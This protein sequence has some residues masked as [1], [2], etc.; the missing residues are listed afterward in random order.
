MTRIQANL[1]LLF[2]GAIWGGG[3]IMQTFAMAS[4]KPLWYIGLRF[5]LATLVILPFALAETRRISRRLTL[6]EAIAFT[7][8]GFS[9]FAGAITQQFGLLTTT[10]TNSGF[11]TGLYVIFVPILSVI[12]LRKAPHWIIWPAALMALTGIFLLSGGSLS[13]LSQGDMLTIVC[14]FFFAIQVLLI[15]VFAAASG[16]PL[17]LSAWQFGLTS[18]A[19]LIVAAAIE[20]VSIE[21]IRSAMMPIIYSG[22]FS[23]GLAFS[24]QV[25][26]QRYTSPSQAAIFLSSEA[27]FAASFGAVFLGETI[28]PVGYVGCAV[29]FLA[30]VLVELVPEILSKR[31]SAR[32][33]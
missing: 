15:G 17:L 22:I 25:I 27:L 6:R 23:S 33:Q 3:F 26:G 9:L 29:I 19:S 30:M 11:L 4:L 31:Q 21:G 1:C 14:A 12:L 5:L 2:A 24:L 18:V 7:A 20:P 32:A 16:R 13:A 10:V 8:I 28:S